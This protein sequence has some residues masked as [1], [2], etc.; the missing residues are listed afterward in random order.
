MDRTSVSVFAVLMGAVAIAYAW[1]TPRPILPTFGEKARSVLTVKA[2]P[3]MGFIPLHLNVEIRQDVEALRGIEVC[4]QLT[5]TG[6][7]GQLSCWKHDAP[8]VLVTRTLTI[9]DEGY[10]EV[11]AFAG[12]RASNAVTV[13]A[14]GMERR[15]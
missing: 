13:R 4:L 1:G 9:Q 8:A 3:Q 10:Y 12:D 2:T 5:G 15:K 6:G 7:E 14:V 11:Q